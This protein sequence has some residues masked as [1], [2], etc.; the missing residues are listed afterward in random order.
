M[1]ELHSI[2][3]AMLAVFTQTSVGECRISTTCTGKSAGGDSG[4]QT[5]DMS[6]TGRPTLPVNPPPNPLT[7]THVE[8]R[9]K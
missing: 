1:S 9:S 6:A 5:E 7:S 2:G 8:R 4:Q 3:G